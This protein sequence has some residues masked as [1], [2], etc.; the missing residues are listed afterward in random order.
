VESKMAKFHKQ[1]PI[2]PLAKT[3]K[4]KQ[5]FVYSKGECT[6]NFTLVIE[7]KTLEDFKECVTEALKDVDAT[8][9]NLK[10]IKGEK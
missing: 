3:L 7:K 5:E 6:L 8:L 4:L 1:P 10:E 2:L 9:A